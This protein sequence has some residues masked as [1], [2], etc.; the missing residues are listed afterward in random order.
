MR[1]FGSLC[2]Q[3]EQPR[4]TSNERSRVCK[5]I[6][7]SYVPREIDSDIHRKHIIFCVEDSQPHDI[8]ETVGNSLQE[9]RWSQALARTTTHVC[10]AIS[11]LNT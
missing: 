2:P 5:N 7:R 3:P 4:A 1:N 9:Y 10:V 6:F 11:A 8:L